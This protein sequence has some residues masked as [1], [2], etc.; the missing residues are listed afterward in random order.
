MKKICLAL[1][2]IAIL[3]CFTACENSSEPAP[4]VPV[5]GISGIEAYSGFVNTLT[6]GEL[7]K[8]RLSF[9]SLY[10]FCLSD[11]T[12]IKFSSTDD[13][14]RQLLYRKRNPF[15]VW[16]Y[17]AFDYYDG[18]TYYYKYKDNWFVDKFRKYDNVQKQDFIAIKETFFT[19]NDVLFDVIYHDGDGYI[20]EATIQSHDK[21]IYYSLNAK[22]TRDMQ[23]TKIKIKAH[24]FN[25]ETNK[26][27]ATDTHFFTYNK[28]N[29]HPA[30]KPPKGL[31]IADI[32]NDHFIEAAD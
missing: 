20:A 5:E 29:S 11:T 2:T 19:G 18:H 3:V 23:F 31:N 1:L 28:I 8:T 14:L 4:R 21:T 27:D 22:L 25:F 15:V 32:E 7:R 26:F 9:H 13:G 12:V 24:S 17:P 16:D 30:I 6:S 10:E